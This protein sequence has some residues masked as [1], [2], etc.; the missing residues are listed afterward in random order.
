MP[1][2]IATPVSIMGEDKSE[3]IPTLQEVVEIGSAFTTDA[4]QTEN[5]RIVADQTIDGDPYDEEF[6][7]LFGD[8]T[9]SETQSPDDNPAQLH[10]D[11]VEANDRIEESASPETDSFD[12]PL[13]IDEVLLKNDDK[14]DFRLDTEAPDLDEHPGETFYAMEPETPEGAT[15]DENHSIA[16]TDDALWLSDWQEETH[17]SPL[18]NENTDS[19]DMLH[20]RAE[21]EI[22][23][24]HS[25]TSIPTGAAQ[26]AANS[27]MAC[28]TSTSQTEAPAHDETPTAA[29][30]P[31]QQPSVDEPAAAINELDIDALSDQ[32]T[33]ALLPEIED[34]LRSKIR[35]V[36]EQHLSADK[37]R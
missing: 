32:I 27:G 37:T 1:F 4:P 34:K 12:N 7:Q 28:G 9:D 3:H 18:V 17:S 19:F 5:I 35:E 22:T 10:M 20:S 11:G 30:V 25:E 21:I 16:D 2:A 8:L 33:D 29:P 13:D 24:Q 6:D 36:L 31:L 26:Q 23:D 14:L 15:A